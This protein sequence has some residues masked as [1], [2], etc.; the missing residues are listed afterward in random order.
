M[1]NP[2]YLIIFAVILAACGSHPKMMNRT[3]LVGY[4][5]DKE[6]GLVQEQQINATK[7]SLS[8]HPTSL[9]VSREIGDERNPSKAVID[10]IE[11][12]YSKN[13]YFLAKF[14]I[15]GKEAIRQ[16]GDFARYSDMVQVLS[17]QMHRFVNVTTPQRDTLPLADYFFDQTY[18]MSDGNTLLLCFDKEKLKN[19]KELEINIAECGMGTGNLKFLFNREDLDAV[20]KMNYTN[21]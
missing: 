11:K 12:K 20:P 13:Y 15:N 9:M 7:V 17:F 18:G 4:L 14:S 3:E 8:Y 19:R 16:L 10:S 5:R 1:R 2:C 6:N 21:Q